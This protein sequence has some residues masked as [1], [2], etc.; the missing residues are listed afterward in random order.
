MNGKRIFALVVIV[1]AVIGTGCQEAADRAAARD[2]GNGETQGTADALSLDQFGTMAAMDVAERQMGL[3][4]TAQAAVVQ[5]TMEAQRAV[6]EVQRIAGTRQAEAATAQA[7]D[8]YVQATTAAAG[9]TAQA[10]ADANATAETRRIEETAEARRIEETA[11]AV[12]IAATEQR[13]RW[14]QDATATAWAREDMAT[15]EASYATRQAEATAAIDRAT[16]QSHQATA[17]RAAAIREERLGGFRDYGLPVILL[18]L[19]GCAVALVV[20]GLRQYSKRPIVYE[21]SLLGDAQPMAVPQIGGGFAFVDLDRQPGPVL[22]VLPNG[23]VNAPLLRS[24]GQEERTV[25]RDQ[26]LDAASRPRL[27]AGHTGPVPQLAADPPQ[28][29]APG[30]Q[31]V[32]IVRW[33]GQAET[34][35]LLPPGQVEAIET[36]WKETE[37]D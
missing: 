21:R 4:A 6:W 31:G 35:G 2:W 10:A 20:Y 37:E 27:G 23:V 34:A 12:A 32:R 3:D 30:L 36:V 16:Q 13:T 29:P 25:A 9:A 11:V 5:A 26:M 17:T 19:V 1:L 8:R 7:W 15:Q 18:L 24:P 22:Q 33:L 28:A 14:E